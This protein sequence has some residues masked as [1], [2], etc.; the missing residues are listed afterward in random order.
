MKSTQAQIRR[1]KVDQ[2][3]SKSSGVLDDP[4]SPAPASVASA[5]KGGSAFLQ[6]LQGQTHIL[7]HVL[8]F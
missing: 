1:Y 7:L 8:L 3:V 4:D 6:S 5:H 2:A